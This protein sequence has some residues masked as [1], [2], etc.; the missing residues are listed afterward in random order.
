MVCFWY[1]WPLYRKYG[2]FSEFS[3]DFESSFRDNWRVNKLCDSIY[4]RVATD[5]INEKWTWIQYCF[6]FWH[7]SFRW[8]VI[9]G[10]IRVL[11]LSIRIPASNLRKL[12]IKLWFTWFKW[13][14]KLE[15]LSSQ[16]RKS[17]RFSRKWLWKWITSNRHYFSRRNPT[18]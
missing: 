11:F 4:W 5:F 15:K 1:W 9:T 13:K 8:I 2:L 6:S 14:L 18:R 12:V 16:W 10:L 3:L 7:G 17:S